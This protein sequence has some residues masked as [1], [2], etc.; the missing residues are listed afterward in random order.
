[1]YFSSNLFRKRT[2]AQKITKSITVI[3]FAI[4][5]IGM[6]LCFFGHRHRNS[7]LEP[8]GTT[9]WAE[10]ENGLSQSSH[11]SHREEYV[12]NGEVITIDPIRGQLQ[13]TSDFHLLA[14]L[15]GTDIKGT[16]GMINEDGSFIC[17]SYRLPFISQYTL[18]DGFTVRYKLYTKTIGDY[19]VC[20]SVERYTRIISI[21]SKIAFV[22]SIFFIVSLIAQISLGAIHKRRVRL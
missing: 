1:M 10:L 22:A 3:S 5:V 6:M 12:I 13:R 9:W 8:Y 15:K 21:G 11:N 7:I 19:D 4:I 2:V 20:L 18:P 17:K 16:G 14:W